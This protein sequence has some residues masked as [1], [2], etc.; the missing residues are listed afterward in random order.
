MIGPFRSPIS[1]GGLKPASGKNS[2][3]KKLGRQMKKLKKKDRIFVNRSLNLASIKSIGFDMDH[4]LALYNR[5]EFETLAF[6]ETLKKFIE[7]GYPAELEALKFDPNFV[8]RGLLVDRDRGNLLKV[9]GYKYVKVAYHGHQKLEKTERHALYNAKGY[10]ADDYLSVDTFFALSETQLFVEIVDYMRRHPNEIQKSYRDVYDDLREFI[11][12]CHKD[13]SIKEHVLSHIDRYI[14]RDPHLGQTLAKLIDGGKKLFLLTNSDWN[15]TSAI[16]DYLLNNQ[17]EEFPR[18]QDYFEYVIVGA[19]K[20]N[21]F[22]GSSPF[23][24]VVPD[25]LLKPHYGPLADKTVYHGGN[26]RLFEQLTQQRGDEIL[27]IGDH[28][29]GDIM[30]S[31][32]L[33]NWRTLLVIEELDDEFDR[34]YEVEPSME[35]ILEAIR[36]E[37][38]YTEAIYEKSAELSSLRRQLARTSSKS[39]RNRLEEKLQSISSEL[40]D[41]ELNLAKTHR[42]I[43][44]LIE[45]R[46]LQFHPIWGELLYS[47][48]VKS[49]FANQIESYACLYTSKISNLK[50]YSANQRFRSWRDTMPHD[51]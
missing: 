18:W 49:R 38:G 50:N 31:K 40:E 41:L 3:R 20:P 43:G 35:S 23:Y 22:T 47:S 48:L 46:E 6:R 27:Y 9:D 21:F 2:F 14:K 10:K 28:I 34:Y 16:M 12:L 37:E 1:E 25:G 36:T 45:S 17:H 7:A 44:Q 30:R 4:T 24:E 11:D 19:G 42:N 33:F 13:G 5:E 8:I 32:E 26:A 51:L 39:K 15:Y 29:Y